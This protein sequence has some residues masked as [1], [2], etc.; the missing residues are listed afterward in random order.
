[1]RGAGPPGAAKAS[2]EVRAAANA[3][4]IARLATLMGSSEVRGLQR[5]RR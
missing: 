5:M 1:M 3:A 2:I 4:A